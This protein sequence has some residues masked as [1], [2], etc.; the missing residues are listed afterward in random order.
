MYRGVDIDDDDVAFETRAAHAYYREYGL[1]LTTTKEASP[2]ELD[3]AIAGTRQ[4]LEDAA[5]LV[6][7]EGNR[8]EELAARRVTDVMFAPVRTFI[9]S[10]SAPGTVQ[11]VVLR[12]VAS[13]GVRE[14]L[15][16]KL[17]GQLAGIGLSPALLA[18]LDQD[19]TLALQKQLALGESFTPTLFV[20]HEVVSGNAAGRL[21]LAHELGHALGLPHS[22]GTGNLMAKSPTGASCEPML[23]AEQLARIASNQ[24]LAPNAEAASLRELSVRIVA[25]VNHLE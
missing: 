8:A 22:T 13:P 11:V 21:V 16:K 4:E 9:R 25:K 12:N 19:S 15:D 18:Y 1:T 20:G 14:I 6:P 24:R 2:T 10:H 5:R 17:G 23:E 3:Y 7:S